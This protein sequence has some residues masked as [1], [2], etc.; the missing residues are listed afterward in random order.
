MQL[1]T[2]QIVRVRSRQYL[3]EEVAPKSSEDTD[4]LVPMALKKA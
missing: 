4:T 1:K 3:V 2:G